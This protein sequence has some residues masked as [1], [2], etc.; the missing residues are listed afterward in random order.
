MIG[1][2]FTAIAGGLTCAVGLVMTSYSCSLPLMF[3]THSFLFGLGSSLILTASFLI[4]A[5]NF[6]KRRSF[7]VGVVSVGGSIGVLVMGPFLQL[8]LDMVGWRGTYRIISAV[9]CLV[10]VSGVTFGDPSENGQKKEEN[11]DWLVESRKVECCSTE[12]APEDDVIESA[13]SD[14]DDSRKQETGNCIERRSSKDK[15]NYITEYTEDPNVTDTAESEKET[16]KLLDFSVFKVP[17]FAILVVSLTLMCL[18]H[19]TPQLHLVSYKYSET[20]P[21]K[22][23]LKCRT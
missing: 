20:P 14:H 9:L 17:S 8:L 3:I 4:T 2:R 12:A 19:Y 22:A 23:R 7:A 16:G 18:G 15:M 11:Q 5:K 13:S 10:C 1:C 21:I 6:R